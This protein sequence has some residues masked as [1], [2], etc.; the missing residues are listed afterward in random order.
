MQL[1][2]LRAIAIEAQQTVDAEF[3]QR[4]HRLHSAAAAEAPDEPSELWQELQVAAAAGG[5]ELLLTDY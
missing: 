4:W 1:Q 5:Q 2:R 3:A